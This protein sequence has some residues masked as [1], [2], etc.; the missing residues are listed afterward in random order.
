MRIGVDV[1]EC[2]KGKFTGL[3][4]VLSNFL[5]N[6]K[7]LEGHEFVFFCNQHTELDSLPE[8]GE[9]V[10]I[11]ERNTLWWDQVKLPTALLKKN[12]EVFFSPY[13]KTPLWRACPYVS[14][15]ADIIPLTVSKYKGYMSILEKI[16]FF[17]FTYLCSHRAASVVTISNDAKEKILRVFRV[18]PWKLKVI[19][20][21]INAGDFQIETEKENKDIIKQ[22]DIDKPYF[23]YVGNFKPHKNLNNLIDAFI[24]L[25]KEVRDNYRL[26]VAGGLEGDLS[27]IRSVIKERKL[28]GKIVS[29]PGGINRKDVITLLNK[30]SAFIFPSLAEGFGMPPIE[31]MAA[32][33]PVISSNVAPMTEVLG[34]A[35]LFFDP[36][37]PDDMSKK[38][39]EL[40]KND[41]LRKKLISKGKERASSFS[42]EKMTKEIM[43][44]L[45]DA[46]RKK[47]LL[48]SNEFPPVKGGI[49][50]HMYN[51]WCRFPREEIVILTA[52]VG[53]EDIKF[54]GGLS[55]V[56]KVYPLGRDVL[57]RMIR[58]AMVIRYAWQQNCVRNVK[59]NHCAQLI[60]SGLAG[61]I[62]KM[63]KGTPY[64]VY[65]YSADVLEF[66]KN[67][68]TNWVM[69]KVFSECEHVIANSI[70][71]KSI[72]K[73][74]NLVSEE[75]IIVSTPAVDTD[76]FNPEKGPGRIREKY[77]IPSDCKVLLTV[78]RL[79]LRKGHKT[80]IEAFSDVLRKYPNVVYLI[81]GEGPEK[82]HL[83]DLVRTNGIEDNVI[84]AGEV[85]ADELIHFYNTCDIFI[86]VPRYIEERGD[87]EGFGIVF[88]EA[89]ACGKPVIA[90]RSGGISEAVVDGRTGILVDPESVDQIKNAVLKI[91]EDEEYAKRLGENGLRR[92][93]EGFS[94][95]SRAEELK[96]Y[97]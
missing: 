64:V 29:I 84:F 31:A 89:N 23:L 1:R 91:L 58:T 69:K 25:P 52:K 93:R 77:G 10:V 4:S 32:G 85:P 63:I 55:V 28:E 60:S 66:S 6:A 3:R 9:R 80:V 45:E 75:K 73:A 78:S 48:V 47:T 90:G 34:D 11:E 96:E 97:I 86:M 19:Y 38:I 71:T 88:L 72:I 33:I 8:Y 79:S 51:L 70:F 43:S 50:T 5:S 81:A 95:E 83:R 35:A 87:V 21:S 62:V 22:Y 16:Y 12:I 61:L 82:T 40:L 37:S 42:P 41:N 18:D 24:L 92:V 15:A 65:V 54:D 39:L 76:V 20:P 53:R 44:V 94:W 17:I 7:V 56:R 26:I 57:S 2:K 68:L 46:G 67:F 14:T 13:I 59:R 74:H 27:A 36:Y 30:A 49:S